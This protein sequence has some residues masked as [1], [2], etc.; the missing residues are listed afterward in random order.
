MRNNKSDKAEQP[1]HTDRTGSQKRRYSRKDY[2]CQLY[3]KAD[4][5]GGFVP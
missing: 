5:L 3:I 1:C 2:T 4:P